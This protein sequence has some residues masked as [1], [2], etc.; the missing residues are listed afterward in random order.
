MYKAAKFFVGRSS[1]LFVDIAMFST[2]YK[3]PCNRV[4][5]NFSLLGFWFS[6]RELVEA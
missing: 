2:I 3:L 1:K 4:R 6:A 5:R